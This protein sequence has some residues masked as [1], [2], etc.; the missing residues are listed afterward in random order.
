[1]L[2]LG[3]LKIINHYPVSTSEKE[4]AE[5]EDKL[6]ALSFSDIKIKRNDLEASSMLAIMY[7]NFI[8]CFLFEK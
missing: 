5:E 7:K 8:Q 4:M 2:Y 6:I 1:M 3:R